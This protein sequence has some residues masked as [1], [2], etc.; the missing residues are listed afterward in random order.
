T[1]FDE[2]P[3]LVGHS[4]GGRVG[5]CLAAKYPERV[6]P[7]ILTGVPLLRS[8]ASRRPPL[9]YR[10]IR[11]LNK[12]GIVSDDRLESERRKRGSADYRA[13][14]GVMRDIFVKVVN[15]SYETQLVAVAE[16]VVML[17]GSDDLEVPVTVAERAKDIRD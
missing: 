5:L 7:L 14:S 12:V 3:V 11:W 4:F 1:E 17:W 8:G 6:G 16:P 13:V 2:P 10:A 15:E 9:G